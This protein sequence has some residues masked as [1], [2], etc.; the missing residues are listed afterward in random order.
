MLF[1]TQI[2]GR[3]IALLPEIC[4]KGLC[5]VFG[6]IIYHSLPE[7]RTNTLRSLHHCFP[8]HDENWRRAILKEHCRRLVEMGL[9]VL[10]SP[11]LSEK[12]AR[13]I[14][15]PPDD[16]T[17]KM[18]RAALKEGPFILM[19]PHMTLSEAIVTIPLHIPEAKGRV[20]VIFRPLKN[21]KLNQ[22]VLDCRSRFGV[23]LLSR[24]AGYSQALKKLETKDGVGLL[25][26]QNASG[27]GSFIHFMGRVAS[28]TELPGIMAHRKQAKAYAVCAERTG[29]WKAKLEFTPLEIG[30]TPIDLTLAANEWLI[31]HLKKSD[32]ACADWLWL[33]NRWGSPKSPRR[34]FGLKDKRN[35]LKEDLRFRNGIKPEAVTQVWFFLPQETKDFRDLPEILEEIHESRPDYA[36]CLISEHSEAKLKDIFKQLPKKIVSLSTIPSQRRACID[37]IAAE[38]PDVWINLRNDLQSLKESRR[39][40]AEQ[41]YGIQT[42]AEAD[43]YLTD[44]APGPTAESWRPFFKRFGLGR[45]NPKHESRPSSDL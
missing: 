35:R 2:I 19:V 8:E 7:R 32:S 34:R 14:I 17:L 4:L 43:K 6:T 37:Q 41:R 18:C 42:I 11:F 38:Y 16:K 26:D 12:R 9:F 5:T 21:P 36:L 44:L 31:E 23:E 22:W 33:H 30:E 13:S 29:F 39:S 24:R 45:F 15:A 10:A 28:A 20:S 25:F 27:K 3:F 1:L 40:L